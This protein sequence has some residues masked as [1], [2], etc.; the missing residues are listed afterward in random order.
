MSYLPSKIEAFASSM[1]FDALTSYLRALLTSHLGGIEV[2]IG[3]IS[4]K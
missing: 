3:Y 4:G 1:E 2:K